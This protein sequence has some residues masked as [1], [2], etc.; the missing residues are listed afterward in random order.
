MNTSKTYITQSNCNFEQLSKWTYCNIDK[1]INFKQ[2]FNKHMCNRA[3]RPKD[4]F[5][6]HILNLY[7]KELLDVIKFFQ[8]PAP[9]VDDVMKIRIAGDLSAH[10]D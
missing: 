6:V 4:S 5:T 1:D 7:V 9:Y 8:D 10:Y 2:K 3:L